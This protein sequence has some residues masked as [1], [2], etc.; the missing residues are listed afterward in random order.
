MLKL[1]QYRWFPMRLNVY[2]WL[3]FFIKMWWIKFIVFYF[4]VVAIFTFQQFFFSFDFWKCRPVFDEIATPNLNLPAKLIINRTKMKSDIKMLK[5]DKI[6]NVSV[7]RLWRYRNMKFF[8][9]RMKSSFYYALLFMSNEM[10]NRKRA[11]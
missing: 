1:C 7:W 10:A 8:N 2:I 11:E 6:I 3:P 9:S 5:H 4:G